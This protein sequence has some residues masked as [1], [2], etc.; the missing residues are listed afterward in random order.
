VHGLQETL[1]RP[2]AER[3]WPLL[4]A[5]PEADRDS[6]E[7]LSAAGVEILPLPLSRFRRSG[8]P[9]EHLRSLTGLV[10]DIR[11]LQQ[12]IR[13]RNIA[14][15]KVCGLHNVHGAIAARRSRKP[16]VWQLLSAMVPAPIRRAAMPFIL[17]GADVVM[18]NGGGPAIQSAFP[19]LSSIGDRWMPFFNPVD[20]ARFRP[21]RDRRE[22]ARQRLGFAPDDIVVGT[23]GNRTVQKGHDIFV[24]AAALARELNRRLRFCIVGAPVES[25]AGW[26]EREVLGKAR[27]L[28]LFDRP[29]LVIVDGGRAVADLLPAFDIFAMTSRSEGIPIA[30]IEAMATGLP[31]VVPDIGGMAETSPHGQTGLVLGTSEPGHHAAAWAAPAANEVLRRIFGEAGRDLALRRYSADA[32]ASIYADAFDQAVAHDGEI[33]A[34]SM[35]GR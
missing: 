21:D 33:S 24:E 12:V 23:V 10:R 3:G 17:R 22:R 27:N 26:Y 19:G 4:V 5:L 25:N 18:T 1:G 9:A 2:L 20:T 6:A 16:L 8:N 11:T 13:D 34:G 32:V 29:D 30:M 35:G 14:V 28:G 7:R 15:V 31:T